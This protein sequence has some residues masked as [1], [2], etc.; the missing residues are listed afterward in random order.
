METYWQ[1]HSKNA[2]FF[3]ENKKRLTLN[4]FSANLVPGAD[5]GNRNWSLSFLKK[6]SKYFET[7][8]MALN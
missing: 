8:I 5:S 7:W 3:K 1:L 6:M 4:Q 2:A